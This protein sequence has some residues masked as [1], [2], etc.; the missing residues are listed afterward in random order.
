MDGFRKQIE[1]DVKKRIKCEENEVNLIYYA[2][3]DFNPIY[4]VITDKNVLVSTI[5]KNEKL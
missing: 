4:K 2:K 5:K 3:E 1:R